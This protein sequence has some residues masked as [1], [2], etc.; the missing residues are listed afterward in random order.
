MSRGVYGNSVN[1]RRGLVDGIDVRSHAVKIL[2]CHARR[3]S[4]DVRCLL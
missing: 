3:S 1:R 4:E 2:A